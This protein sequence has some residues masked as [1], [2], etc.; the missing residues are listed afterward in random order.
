MQFA[1]ADFLP[2]KESYTDLPVFMQKKRDFF[3]EMMLQ[4]RFKPLPSFGS[5]FQLYSF[6]DISDESAMG[7]QK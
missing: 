4:T 7:S 5:Y 3:Q 2:K 1:L 6:N